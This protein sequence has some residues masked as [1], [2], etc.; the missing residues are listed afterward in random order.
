[1]Q[2]LRKIPRRLL[3]SSLLVLLVLAVFLQVGNHSFVN[4]DDPQYVYENPHVQRGLTKESLAWAFTSTGQAN[5]HPLTWLSHMTDVELF[6]LDAGWHHRVSVLFHLLN[7]VLLFL[8]LQRM[9]GG[10]WQSA[11]VA[12]LFGVHPL[13]V[14]SVAWVAERKDVLSAFFWMLSLWAYAAYAERKGAARYGLV[15]SFFF[16]GL[17][18]KPM[19]VTLPFVLLLLDYW[20]LGRMNRFLDLLAEKAPLFLLS[21]G[22]CAATYAAQQREG[23]IPPADL[24]PLAVRVANAVVSYV[25]YLGKTVWPASLTV[26]YPHPWRTA[27]SIPFLAVAGASTGLVAL[28]ALALRDAMRRPYLLVGWFW[29]VGTLIPVIG[30]VQVGGQAMADRYTYLPL[31]GLFIMVAWGI[32]DLLD[33]WRLRTRLAGAAGGVVLLALA[34]GAWF[35]VSHWKNS[36]ALFGHAAR[37]S[38]PNALA[39]YYLGNA[40]GAEG[41]T[42]EAIFQYLQALT[43]NPY[44]F[45]ARYNLANALETAGRNEDAIANYREVLRLK[46]GL[47]EAHN[48]LGIALADTGRLEEA[49]SHFR[50]ALRL[51]PGSADAIRNLGLALENREKARTE[52]KQ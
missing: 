52:K 40:L 41:R 49:I 9:T 7:T 35:Q 11:F 18:S 28:T 13:H 37:V 38:S 16:L 4:F 27:D 39:H 33:R 14:E 31:I 17:L 36:V 12:G 47:A 29:F 43:V 42:D 3:I 25:R 19:V 45:E 50:E 5:W 22:S 24:F 1:M 23:A 6:G 8:V 46:P 34:A 10:L 20:P 15:V 26:F 2:A 21:V 32:P 44:Y 51:A 48:N 30:L